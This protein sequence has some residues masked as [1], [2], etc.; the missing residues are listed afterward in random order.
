LGWAALD[1]AGPDCAVLGWAGPDWAGPDGAGPDW[2]G[3]AA[4]AVDGADECDRATWA[5]AAGRPCPA[6]PP[7]PPEPQPAPRM[8]TGSASA[9]HGQRRM[10]SSLRAASQPGASVGPPPPS[11]HVTTLT[12]DSLTCGTEC[13]TPGPGT[14]PFPG[15]GR[16]WILIELV[17]NGHG[18][19]GRPR[20]RKMRRMGQLGRI[21]LSLG[22]G[23][24]PY[25]HIGP[26]T[27]RGT[28]RTAVGRP[29]V[30][31][32]GGR[33]PARCSAS[34][35]SRPRRDVSRKGKTPSWSITSTPPLTWSSSRSARGNPRTR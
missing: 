18:D 9:A 31:R 34:A 14:C 1:W 30:G 32:P 10:K 25:G 27:V 15:F 12:A 19:P 26:H 17:L 24:A 4:G 21:G 6:A 23:I 20:P 5:T 8:M 2:A 16:C 3:V 28:R 29:L 33:G 13:P 35:A 7:P 22:T 11:Q